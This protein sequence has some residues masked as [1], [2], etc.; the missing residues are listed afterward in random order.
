V[1]VARKVLASVWHMFRKGGVAYDDA[2][3]VAAATAASAKIAR[4]LRQRTAQLGAVVKDDVTME[5]LRLAHN[6][7]SEILGAA[8]VTRFSVPPFVDGDID[9]L[10]LPMRV[11]NC[12]RRASIMS[13][14][15]LV[16][17]VI[18][19]QL[20]TVK[21]IGSKSADEILNALVQGGYVK[22]NGNGTQEQT[23]QE[24]KPE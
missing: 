22:E 24:R 12:L 18:T 9:A 4:S 15:S 14:S 23:T 21:G 8:P 10:K 11:A 6:A 3:H 13:L 7:L 2:Q 20:S 17:K 19:D 1:A 5:E 16:L